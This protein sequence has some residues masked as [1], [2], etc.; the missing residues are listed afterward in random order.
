MLATALDARTW[1]RVIVPHKPHLR[2][3]WWS[4]QEFLRFVNHGNKRSTM[5]IR[6]TISRCAD[7]HFVLLPSPHRAQ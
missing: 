5:Y 6:V 7:S 1:P 3:E 2:R 4:I